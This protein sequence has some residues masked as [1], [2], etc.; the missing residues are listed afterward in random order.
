MD[1]VAEMDVL[2]KVL[3]RE[4]IQQWGKIWFVKAARVIEAFLEQSMGDERQ[5]C[6][7]P[8]SPL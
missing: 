6:H 3:G 7:I 8:I 1:D 4:L 5:C 2:Q